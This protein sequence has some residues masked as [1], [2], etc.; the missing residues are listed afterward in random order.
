MIRKQM[1]LVAAVI[2]SMLFMFP[3]CVPFPGPHGPVIDNNPN[4]A[5]MVGHNAPIPW[6]IS[7]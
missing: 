4:Q 1:L 7:G 3:T 6:E 5:E 2:M